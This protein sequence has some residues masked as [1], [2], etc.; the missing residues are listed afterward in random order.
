MK[1]RIEIATPIYIKPVFP[2]QTVTNK[3]A[4]LAATLA[5]VYKW[6]GLF[7]GPVLLV[8]SRLRHEESKL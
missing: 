7:L 3:S 1:S 2:L 6:R 4:T 5:A 8:A